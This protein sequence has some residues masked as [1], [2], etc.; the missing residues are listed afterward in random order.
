MV[1]VRNKVTKKSFAANILNKEN[2]ILQT[3]RIDN[4]EVA[5]YPI[6]FKRNKCIIRDMVFRYVCK[7]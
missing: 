1:G 4:I 3:I 2:F 5:L 7:L 6:S